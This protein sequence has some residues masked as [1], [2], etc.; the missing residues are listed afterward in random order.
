M[1]SD[2]GSA[3]AK[4]TLKDS[5]SVGRDN[6]R[7]NFSPISTTAQRDTTVPTQNTSTS[8]S[9]QRD[10]SSAQTSNSASDAGKNSSLH[11][12]N[13][14]SVPVNSENCRLRA[15]LQSK[16][17]HRAYELYQQ[18]GTSHGDD[19]H[20]WLRAE[21]EILE[22]I[23]EVRQADS[24]YS[25]ITRL[26][27][28]GAEDISVTVEPN[29]GLIFADKQQSSDANGFV[30]PDGS[31][32]SRRSVFFVADWPGQVDPATATAQLRQGNLVLTV[33]RAGIISEDSKSPQIGH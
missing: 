29:R 26:D 32:S 4:D 25:V 11:E 6:T 8:P 10:N 22:R 21:S 16:V 15:E 31:H 9:V 20:H 2:T 30:N 3:K 19:L 18:N 28:F 7:E 17:A 5:S 27:G 13:S 33:K 23:P 1:A 24:T 12:A 14:V